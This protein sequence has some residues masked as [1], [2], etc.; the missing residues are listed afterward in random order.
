[1]TETQLFAAYADS[2]L[3]EQFEE[4][5]RWHEEWL[6]AHPHEE[7]G[8]RKVRAGMATAYRECAR[9][10]RE[11]IPPIEPTWEER[12]AFLDELQRMDN[13]PW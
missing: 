12:K 1:M 8:Q 7:M 6:A 4:R 9:I 3:V 5:A 11:S 2:N 13:V 10:A